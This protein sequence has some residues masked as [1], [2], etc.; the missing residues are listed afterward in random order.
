MT[1]KVSVK[2]RTSTSEPEI[3]IENDKF[4]WPETGVEAKKLKS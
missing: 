4:P 2:T 1:I 3:L